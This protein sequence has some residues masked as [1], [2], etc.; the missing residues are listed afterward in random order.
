MKFDKPTKI[1]LACVLSLFLLFSTASCAFMQDAFADTVL[2]TTS[3]IKPE[4]KDLVFKPGIE[5]IKLIPQ[6]VRE[7]LAENGQELVVALPEDLIDPTIGVKLDNPNQ[8]TL[9]NILGIGWSIASTFVPQLAAFEGIGI[10]LSRRKRGHYMEVVRN[11]NPL[12]G[13]GQVDVKEAAL[14]LVRAVGMAHSSNGSK[15]AHETSTS[16]PVNG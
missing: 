3:N 2:T 14:S 5:Q 15:S 12:D 7:K 6:D 1:I 4:S 9:G 10:L 16:G 8:D 13:T 11:L